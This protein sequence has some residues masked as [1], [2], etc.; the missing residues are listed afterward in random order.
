[1]YNN[2]IDCRRFETTIPPETL[3][4]GNEQI[5]ERIKVSDRL[6]KNELNWEKP[7]NEP[8]AVVRT[9][10]SKDSTVHLCCNR[11]KLRSTLDKE[12]GKRSNAC[13]CKTDRS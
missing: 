12:L 11:G 5:C 9:I 3:R 2:V 1:M 13:L 6:N 7:F 8:N 4:R 10:L